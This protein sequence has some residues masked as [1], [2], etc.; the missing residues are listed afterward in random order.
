MPVVA[1]GA[2]L[3]GGLLLALG[4]AAGLGRPTQLV[5]MTAGALLYTAGGIISAQALMVA[6]VS[7]SPPAERGAYLAFIQILV[8][9]SLAVTP[10]LVTVFL[11]HWPA[12]LWWLL[13]AV[14]GYVAVDMLTHTRRFAAELAEATSRSA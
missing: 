5:V 14:V 12:G 2:L 9:L 6:L 7:I 10:L 11:E 13:L 1:V 8:G 3:H 4:L